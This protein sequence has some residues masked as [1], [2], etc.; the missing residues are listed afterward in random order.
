MSNQAKRLSDCPAERLAQCRGEGMPPAGGRL[1]DPSPKDYA[2][3][4]ASYLATAADQ[5]LADYQAYTLAQMIANEGGDDGE[6]E[7]TDAIDQ[8]RDDLHEGLSNLRSMTYEF[9]KRRDRAIQL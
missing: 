7:L 8:A 5:V 1:F 3:E 9:R 2:I 4:H 6:E